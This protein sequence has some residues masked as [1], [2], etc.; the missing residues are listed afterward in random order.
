MQAP[1]NRWQQWVQ[2]EWCRQLER[3][4][5]IFQALINVLYNNHPKSFILF[6]LRITLNGDNDSYMIYL[7]P[8]SNHLENSTGLLGCYTNMVISIASQKG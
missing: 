4:A 2:G 1:E 3:S 5:V 8:V 6:Y 7:I